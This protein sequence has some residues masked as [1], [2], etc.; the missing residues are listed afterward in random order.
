MKDN[1]NLL[2][3]AAA[4]GAYLY[5]KRGPVYQTSPR[6]YTG[7]VG[8][9][10][11]TVGTGVNQIEG[12]ALAGFLRSISGSLG[13]ATSRYLTQP[14]V[15]PAVTGAIQETVGLEWDGGMPTMDG[16]G[17]LLSSMWA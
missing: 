4:V 16:A 12:G 13:N 8:S 15:A 17:N 11:G 6:R 3:V 1:S 5:L 10:P 14:V 2:L 7:G 9:M